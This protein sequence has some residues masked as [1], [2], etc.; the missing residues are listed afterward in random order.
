MVVPRGDGA[1]V[2]REPTDPSGNDELYCPFALRENPAGSTAQ[3]DSV[4]WALEH[5]LVS[6]G[7]E[8]EQL[9]SACLG[10][11]AAYTHPEVPP[12][13]LTLAAVWTTLFCAID[14]RVESSRVGALALSRYL[15]EVLAAYRGSTQEGSDTL[16][17]GFGHFGKRLRELTGA[18]VADQFGAELERLFTAYVWEEINRQNEATLDYSAYRL[19]RVT[20]IGLRLQ[21][22]FSQA[23]C[24][25]GAPSSGAVAHLLELEQVTC[26][27]V[28]WANDI[29]TYE[30]ELAAGEAH[31]LVAVLMRTERL[32]VRE[33][34]MRARSLHDEEVCIF[35][36]IQARLR[37][38]EPTDNA[39]EYHLCHLRDWMR[40]HLHWAG[41]NG[42]YRP[43]TLAA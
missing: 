20:T 29:F 31:N 36:R 39:A 35:L 2:S 15:S 3:R 30:K 38:G 43:G 4:E 5:G 28:G 23:V 41:R 17:R 32:P 19:M 40:G 37:E 22:L 26:R 33:A 1:A 42:R 25:W 34:L 13:L 24:P 10:E 16:A 7:A 12:D 6:R 21:F 14:D 9:R 11:L 27:V 8:L 18:P